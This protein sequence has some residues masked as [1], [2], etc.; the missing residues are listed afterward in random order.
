MTVVQSRVLITGEKRSSEGK[1]S[2]FR[3]SQEDGSGVDWSGGQQG[4]TGRGL[5]VPSELC[6]LLPPYHALLRQGVSTVVYDL[7]PAP[8]RVRAGWWSTHLQSCGDVAERVPVREDPAPEQQCTL[9]GVLTLKGQG[10]ADSCAQVY[11]SREYWPDKGRER[12]ARAILEPGAQSKVLKACDFF[13]RGCWR[14]GGQRCT[15][16]AWKSRPHGR[17]RYL[18]PLGPKGT[19][20]APTPARA[21]GGERGAGGGAFERNLTPV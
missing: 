13:H 12:P 16:T 14:E 17:E 2:S 15:R 20:G 8:S 7:S 19:A 11:S 18:L 21:V 4:G 3:D 1:R 9:W 5:D 10:D 6:P